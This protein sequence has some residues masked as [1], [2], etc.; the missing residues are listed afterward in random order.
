MTPDERRALGARLKAEREAHGLTQRQLAERIAAA[1]SGPQ[2]P[3]LDTLT[4]YVKRWERGKAAISARY[5]AAYAEALGI[6]R[7]ELLG[8]PSPIVER[9][10]R[11]RTGRMAG[12]VQCRRW[13]QRLPGNRDPSP[14]LRLCPPP[15]AAGAAGGR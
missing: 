6:D 9:R 10:C 2:V 11:R 15:S 3:A 14:G 12:A 8:D 13:R 7:A 4:E 5:R 1:V